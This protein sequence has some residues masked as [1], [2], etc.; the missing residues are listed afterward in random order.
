MDT[1]STLYEILKH[2]IIWYLDNCAVSTLVFKANK[3][4]MFEANKFLSLYFFSR[5]LNGNKLHLL[6]VQWMVSFKY[7]KD[8]N[9]LWTHS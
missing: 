2:Y 7:K 6:K 9:N 3:L 1:E 4:F 8:Q 5:N